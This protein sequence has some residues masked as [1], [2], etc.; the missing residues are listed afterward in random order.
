MQSAYPDNKTL[1]LGP[2]VT[3]Y[4]GHMVMTNV[5]P[6]SKRKYINLDT[7]FRDDYA[8]YDPSAVAVCTITL[9]ER[10]NNVKSMTVRNMELPITFYNVS[11]NVGNHAFELEVVSTGT[12]Y[13]IALPNNEYTVTSL[14]AAINA[15]L[16]AIPSLVV[17]SVSF[18]AHPAGNGKTMVQNNNG[19]AVVR[20]HFDT[21]SPST[22]K[23]SLGW[24]LGFR[25]RTVLVPANSTAVSEGIYELTTSRYL[26]LVVDEFVGGA[27]NS[28]LAPRTTSLVQKNI[29]ARI[30]INRSSFGFGSWLIAN[31]FNGLLLSDR[32]VY[33]GKVDVQRLHLKLVDECGVPVCLNGAE[34]S[35][36]LEVEYE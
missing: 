17:Q 19:T 6:P 27:P 2:Q 36:C 18:F 13:P 7:V 30:A 11:D 33:A 23:R 26:Y 32:R 29:L 15:Q 1:F 25:T 35:L 5:T 8:E 12:R 34:Y 24:L 4:D 31:N 16:L 14:F 21:V 28:F 10:I 20:L 3:Q 22:P 9:P